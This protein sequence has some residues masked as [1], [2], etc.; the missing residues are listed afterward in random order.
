MTIMDSRA[1]LF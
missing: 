1:P